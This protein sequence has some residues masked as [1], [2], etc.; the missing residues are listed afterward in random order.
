MV[1]LLILCLHASPCGFDAPPAG[2]LMV[3]FCFSVFMRPSQ[4]IDPRSLYVCYRK[5]V[6][7]TDEVAFTEG[8][9]PVRTHSTVY[10]GVTG[11]L[12]TLFT[13]ANS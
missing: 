1:A 11:V 8:Q 9:Q 12:F 2:E 7:L 10:Y 4:R 6:K 3:A 13:L 5:L